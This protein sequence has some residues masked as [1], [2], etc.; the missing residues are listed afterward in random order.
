MTFFKKADRNRLVNC[1][2]KNILIYKKCDPL[3]FAKN[4][5]SYYKF[6]PAI[7]IIIGIKIAEI[8][9]KLHKNNTV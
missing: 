9:G 8:H 6:I 7:L 2:V 3:Y 4:Y 5:Y 1:A